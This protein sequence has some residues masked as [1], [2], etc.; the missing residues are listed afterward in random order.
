MKRLLLFSSIFLFIGFHPAIAQ[1]PSLAVLGVVNQIEDEAWRDARV[2]M[3][4]R[5]VLVELMSESD[6]FTLLEE[7][8]EIR[9]RLQTLSEGVWKLSEDES[10]ADAAAKDLEV[11]R[12]DY[13]LFGRVVYFGRPRSQASIGFFHRNV[14]TTQIEV[15]VTLADRRTQKQIKRRGKGNSRTAANSAVFAF[16]ERGVDFDKSNVG[17]AT[18][19]ALE[20]AVDRILEELN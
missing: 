19:E 1:K 17:I 2:G 14:R 9:E 4:V 15:E 5:A 16:N 3:G 7:R 8:V 12:P 20:D 18:R 13:F 6:Q 10:P 11:L